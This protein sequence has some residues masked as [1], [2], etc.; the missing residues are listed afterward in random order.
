MLFTGALECMSRDLAEDCVAR[1]G[2][3]IE[4]GVTKKTSILVLGDNFR[5]DTFTD[6]RNTFLTT[7]KARKAVGYRD[8][9]QPIEFWSEVDF[10]QALMTTDVSPFRER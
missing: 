8:L 1:A 2:G 3:H 4:K 10:V 5:G 9:G 6:F 7:S